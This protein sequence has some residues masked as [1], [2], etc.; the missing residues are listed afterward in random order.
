MVLFPHSQKVMSLIPVFDPHSDNFTDE[1]L[2]L[3]F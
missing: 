2:E 1:T 3:K